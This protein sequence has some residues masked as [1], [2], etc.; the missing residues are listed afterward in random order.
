MIQKIARKKTITERESMYIRDD[1][2]QKQPSYKNI[3]SIK[4]EK[5]DGQEISYNLDSF[6][7]DFGYTGAC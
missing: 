5:I 2:I 3:I 6:C 4:I 1:Y 7:K